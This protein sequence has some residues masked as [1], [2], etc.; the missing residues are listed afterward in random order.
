MVGGSMGNMICVH[1]IVAAS[2]VVGLFGMEGA[3]IKRNMIPMLFYAASVGV[4]AIFWPTGWRGKS[5]R[6]PPSGGCRMGRGC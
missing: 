6:R 2:A 5:F 1:N 4:P 3:I